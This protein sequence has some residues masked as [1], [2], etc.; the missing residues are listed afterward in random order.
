MNDSGYEST[1]AGFSLG[2]AFEQYDDFYFR[3][4]FNTS[5]EELNTNSSASANLK[6]QKGSYFTTDIGYTLD[7]DKRN[8]RFQTTDGFQ[9]KFTQ[10]IPLIS[11]SNTLLNGYQLDTFYTYDNITSSLGLYLRAVTGLSLIHI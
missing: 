4:N 5:Y 10:N 6:K 11:E 3:P 7:L 9:S 2:T 8:Q 1:N